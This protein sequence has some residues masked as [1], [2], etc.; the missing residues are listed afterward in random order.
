MKYLFAF[1]FLSIP[2]STLLHTEAAF[3]KSLGQELA[4]IRAAREARQNQAIQYYKDG[5]NYSKRGVP[6][7]RNT[8]EVD[9]NE[10]QRRNDRDVATRNRK[11]PTQDKVYIPSKK[12]Y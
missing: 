12:G 6:Q 2:V 4:E 5:F 7:K 11:R 10:I 3:S 1:L 9:Q 8:P